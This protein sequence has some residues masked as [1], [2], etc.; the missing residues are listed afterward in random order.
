VGV[1]VGGRRSWTLRLCCDCGA[2]II[3]ACP[4]SA[5]LQAQ[6]EAASGAAA[7]AAGPP[8]AQ[9]AALLVGALS[10]RT[11]TTARQQ[12]LGSL[13]DALG[14]HPDD[15]ARLGLPPPAAGAAAAAAAGGGYAGAADGG[16]WAAGA[17]AAAAAQ[18]GYGYGAAADI[19]PPR[20]AGGGGG[21]GRRRRGVLG[22]VV[23]ALF[24]GGGGGG[25]GGAG[26]A[27]ACVVVGCVAGW[28]TASMC[29]VGPTSAPDHTRV[30]S[31]ALLVRT[32]QSRRPLL[33]RWRT[34]GLA[35]YWRPSKTSS[36][37]SSSKRQRLLHSPL[38][39]VTQQ[40]HPARPWQQQAAAW[41]ARCPPRPTSACRLQLTALVLLLLLLHTTA[42]LPRQIA[43]QAWALV[44]LLV[45]RLAAPAPRAATRRRAVCSPRRR[46]LRVLLLL[47]LLSVVVLPAPAARQQ[48]QQQQQCR[49]VAWVAP[50]S[51]RSW[52]LRRRPC[53]SSSRRRAA[54]QAR[55]A[56]AP[57]AAA[58]AARPRSRS[59]TSS[60]MVRWVGWAR[61]ARCRQACSMA[62][63][64]ALVRW[65]R[66]A[67][68]AAAAS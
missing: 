37:S 54:R 68:L 44:G 11:G 53:S 39:Q 45:A 16:G 63:A 38:P 20:D 26:T 50:A 61:A 57:A 15:R 31:L 56:A 28:R 65:E 7:A 6:Q 24:G 60:S 14:L 46:H 18:A 2:G 59:S 4:A 43:R 48:R 49:R 66:R 64:V 34:L 40:Q 23:G 5:P 9:L 3:H 8:R 36:S 21:G 10:A 30:P 42:A 17:G 19:T 58:A 33:A 47:L 29:A 1:Q 62:A 55:A 32:Q 67:C 13:A 22:R 51:M 35:S 25:S 41:E 27:G 52:R 12:G